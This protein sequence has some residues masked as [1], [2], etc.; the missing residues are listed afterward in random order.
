MRAPLF[1]LLFALS[2]T[3]AAQPA[4]TP[5]GVP[6]VR[7]ELSTFDFTP[8]TIRLRAGQP[9]IL[10]LFNRGD[11]DHN[12]QAPLFFLQATNVSGPVRNGK[13][14][15][16]GGQTIDVRLTPRRGTFRLKCGHTMHATM[17]MEGDIV[18]Q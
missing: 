2:A 3:A 5:D 1:A 18:V 12:F 10:R 14:E 13:V 6:I 15:V 11:R 4:A 9:V 7:V 8:A 16:P 17:G